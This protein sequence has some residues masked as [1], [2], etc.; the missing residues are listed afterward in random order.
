MLLL[1]GVTGDLA[2]PK[3][4][5]GSLAIYLC[6]RRHIGTVMSNSLSPYPRVASLFHPVGVREGDVAFWI[7][8]GTDCAS[9]HNRRHALGDF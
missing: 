7:T 9:S 3:G 4:S 2:D 6:P 1:T 8:T 5:G